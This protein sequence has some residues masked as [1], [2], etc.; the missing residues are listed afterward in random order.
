MQYQILKLLVDT[1]LAVREP[2]WARMKR[3]LVVTALLFAFWIT[4]AD[5]KKKKKK[6]K[7]RESI[8]QQPGLENDF[9]TKAEMEAFLKAEEDREKEAAEQPPRWNE[10]VLLGPPSES[11]LQIGMVSGRQKC[12]KQA[13]V[14]Q[15]ILVH[16]ETRL[17]VN[18]T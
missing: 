16:Y 7:R 13:N 4:V 9:T 11:G 12:K 10:N 17:Q 8:L 1:E 6:K 14:G 15:K 2:L 3:L 5:A 18:S